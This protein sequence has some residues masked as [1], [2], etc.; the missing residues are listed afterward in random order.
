MLMMAG[1]HEDEYEGQIALTKL[2][3]ELEPDKTSGTRVLYAP[4]LIRPLI[5]DGSTSSRT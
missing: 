4:G 5:A 3:R 2:A 1:N